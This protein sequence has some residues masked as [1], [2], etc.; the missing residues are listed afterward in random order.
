MKKSFTAAIGLLL[1]LPAVVVLQPAACAAQV[2]A[3]APLKNQDVLDMLKA[4][5]SPEIV[6]AKI[7][8][9]PN[10]FD[11]SLDGLR[12]LKSDNVPDVVVLAMVDTAPS[13]LTSE[14][15]KTARGTEIRDFVP[16]LEALIWPLVLTVGV[17][18]WLGPISRLLEAL[19]KRIESGARIELWALVLGEVP[20]DEEIYYRDA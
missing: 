11:T 12:Q 8:K 2:R 20:E 18:V 4:G 14:D 3:A 1:A 10:S 9:S 13:D 5:F 17:L 6:A 15:K 16:L 7:R 19:I